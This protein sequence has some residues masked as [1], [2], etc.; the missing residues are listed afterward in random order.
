MI[1]IF[2]FVAWCNIGYVNWEPW[3]PKVGFVLFSSRLIRR[4]NV[5]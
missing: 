5:E 4:Q 2:S 1:N 3:L